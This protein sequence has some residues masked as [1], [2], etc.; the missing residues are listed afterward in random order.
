MGQGHRHTLCWQ[1]AFL[2]CSLSFDSLLLSPGLFSWRSCCCHV[3]RSNV[4][5]T[6]A[7][8][9]LCSVDKAGTC[10][11]GIHPFACI[12]ARGP[13]CPICVRSIPSSGPRLFQAVP[14]QE[15]DGFGEYQTLPNTIALQAASYDFMLVRVCCN[16]CGCCRRFLAVQSLSF[17]VNMAFCCAFSAFRR[18]TWQMSALTV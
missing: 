14:V 5:L 18:F 15:R 6:A 11:L 7:A 12:C 17:R 4:P 3:E 10:V 2:S 13:V 8:C 9:R 1:L 16:T